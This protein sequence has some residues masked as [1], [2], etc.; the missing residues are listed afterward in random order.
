MIKRDLTKILSKK[1]G[2]PVNFSGRIVNTMLNAIKSDLKKDNRVE[3]RGFGS[4]EVNNKWGK[5]RVQFN[6][7]KNILK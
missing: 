7:S 6:P 1:Y 3:F 5:D 2:L 4:F